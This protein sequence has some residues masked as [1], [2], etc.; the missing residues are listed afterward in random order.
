MRI[1]KSQITKKLQKLLSVILIAD[2]GRPSPRFAV[3]LW[4]FCGC[5]S[6]FPA[7]QTLLE[8]GIGKYSYLELLA[9]TPDVIKMF[10]YKKWQQMGG[11]GNLITK[12]YFQ[13]RASFDKTDR[14]REVYRITES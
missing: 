11:M 4:L 8:N 13:F 12:R 7:K 1:G 5:P 10:T 9:R 2:V 3:V 14:G 6:L